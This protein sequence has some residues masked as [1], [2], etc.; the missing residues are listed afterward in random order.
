M[1]FEYSKKFQSELNHLLSKTKNSPYYSLYTQAHLGGENSR[2]AV[3][4]KHLIPEIKYHCPN[5][6]NKSILD[7]GAGTGSTTLVLAKHFGHIDAFDTDQKAL[8]LCNLRLKENGLGEKVT[9]FKTTNLSSINKKYDFILMN[10]VIE[11]IP[12][13]KKDLRRKV[14]RQAF[15]L[16]KP[17]GYLYINDTPNRLFP[18]DRHTTNKWF[19]PWT[20]PGNRWAFNQAK[21]M[22]LYPQSQHKS[23]KL[24]EDGAWGATYLELKKYLKAF[25]YKVLNLEKNHDRYLAY[26]SRSSKK[27]RCFETLLYYTFVKIFKLPLTTFWPSINNLIIKKITD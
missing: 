11:H 16:L 12:L 19:I 23:I 27:R 22:G 3:F 1:T 8:L 18:L 26:S 4:E 5:L 6:K 10:A 7:L 13:S 9:I 15:S 14:I 21:N 17:G 25:N 2:E 20:R 24:E